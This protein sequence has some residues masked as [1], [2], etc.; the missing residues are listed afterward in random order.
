MS[1]RLKIPRG[2]LRTPPL[3]SLFS[4]LVSS[5]TTGLGPY[6]VRADRPSYN[7]EI[8]G[9]GNAELLLNL[10]RLRYDDTPL[11]L[12]LG[13]VVSQ[14]SVNSSIN[15]AGQVGWPTYTGSATLGG[16]VGYSESPTIT[17][18]P[19]AGVDYAERLLSPISLD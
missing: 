18:T 5:C 1:S 17:Y 3:L 12:E 11:F 16:S 2:L 13:A 14:Y 10:V 6:A 7:Q 19:L 4:I 15:S 9:S 8:L